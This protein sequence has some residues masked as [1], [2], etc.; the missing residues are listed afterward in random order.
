MR[1]LDRLAQT[2]DPARDV[3]V[4]CAWDSDL[5][6]V[7]VGLTN[8][9]LLRLQETFRR[10]EP[11]IREVFARLMQG[12]ADAGGTAECRRPGRVYLKLRTAE[13]ECGK[14]RAGRSPGEAGAGDRPALEPG[15]RRLCLPELRSG[16][17]GGVPEAGVS[18][19]GI[20][21]REPVSRVGARL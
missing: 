8:E 11:P 7:N 2:G 4:A 13:H 15:P 9:S 1:E 12:W 19:A 16:G 5:P 21:V 17:G 10:C 18:A 3:E 20:L 14:C 6:Q